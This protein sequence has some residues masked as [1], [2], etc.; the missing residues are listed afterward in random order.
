MS[1]AFRIG[2]SCLSAFLSPG[3]QQLQQLRGRQLAAQEAV[4][5]MQRADFDRSSCQSE[6]SYG[7]GRIYQGTILPGLDRNWQ[8]Q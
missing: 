5:H 8:R 3:A 4:G 7:C 2:N 1:L 6:H